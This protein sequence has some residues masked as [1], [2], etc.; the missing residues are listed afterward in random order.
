MSF[1]GKAGF[2]VAALGLAAG[3]VFGAGQAEAASLHGAIAFSPGQWTYESSFDWPTSQEA[4]EVALARCGYDDCEVAVSWANGCGALVWNK[5]GWVAAAWG[6]TRSEAVR[7]AI[8]KL[9]EGVPLARLA[10]FGSSDLSGTKV[11]EVVC[12]SNAH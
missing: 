7:N 10:N 12:T 11:V 6:P 8:D 2:A 4:H 1:M 9:A 3:S 5:E